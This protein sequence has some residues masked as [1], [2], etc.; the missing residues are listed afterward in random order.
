[1]STIEK[2]GC[3]E[4]GEK[5]GAQDEWTKRDLK[6][7]SLGESRRRSK[8]QER[9]ESQLKKPDRRGGLGGERVR[10]NPNPLV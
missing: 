6:S 9:E 1:M 3:G 8:G 4:L 10:T 7:T 2:M 5:G